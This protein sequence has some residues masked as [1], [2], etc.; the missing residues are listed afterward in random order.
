MK[1]AAD[2]IREAQEGVAGAPPGPSPT[3]KTAADYIRE[4]SQEEDP[5]GLVDRAKDLA[6]RGI[7]ATLNPQEE[8][9][10]AGIAESMY[11]QT[12]AQAR[13]QSTS[14]HYP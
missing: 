12:V 14:F 9:P 13:L 6:A 11:P 3:M 1:T 4:A 8:N 7:Q 10:N 2:Y 5:P